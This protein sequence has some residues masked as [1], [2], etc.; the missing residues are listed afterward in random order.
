MQTGKLRLVN[1]ASCGVMIAMLQFVL[2]FLHFC[3]LRERGERVDE[4]VHRRGE[5]TGEGLERWLVWC[6]W[7]RPE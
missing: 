4:F 2:G 7:V 6:I 3:L 1:P 5:E